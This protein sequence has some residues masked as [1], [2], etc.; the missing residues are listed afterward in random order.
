MPLL[1]IWKSS[2]DAVLSMNI[3][4]LVNI[5]GD[6]NLRDE[7]ETSSELRYLLQQVDTDKL[8]EYARYCCSDSFTNSGFVLQD[9][10]NELGSRLGYRVDAG[11]YRG[12]RG[13]IG[14]DGIWRHPGARTLIIEVKTTDYYTIDL[15]QIF[16]YRNRLEETNS[17]PDDSAVLFVVGR[18]DS[19]SLEAQIRGSR[20]AWDARLVSVESLIKMVKIHESTGE[21]D[22]GSRIRTLLEPIEYTRVDR[23][24]DV[25]FETVADAQI[26]TETIE[27]ST[28]ND[29]IRLSPDPLETPH[30][31]DTVNQERTSSSAIGLLRNSCVDAINRRYGIELKK[32]SQALFSTENSEYKICVSFSKRYPGKD[33]THYWYAYHP[34]QDEFLSD[35]K[36]GFLVFACADRR[37]CFAIPRDFVISVL[38][39]MN[40][41]V[42]EDRFYWHVY[43]SDVGSEVEW[44]FP[45]VGERT[46]IQ[47]FS[48]K[49][50]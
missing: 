9:I 23:L 40:Q 33:G 3:S 35:A 38:D 2:R 22:T 43:L 13:Q 47:K 48:I 18:D 24:V 45:H 41:T 39:K 25:V 6:G 46:S 50:D 37:E 44:K 4:Q 20:Y 29:K 10:V 11:L 31:E 34:K 7:S 5:A 1:D 21:L 32:E 14:F 8:A 12:R 19:N 17:I 15:S 27:E 36:F 26:H 42:K 30:T 28:F 49:F 16:N